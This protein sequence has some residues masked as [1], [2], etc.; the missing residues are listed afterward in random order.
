MNFEEMKPIYNMLI[1][2]LKPLGFSL[3]LQELE[4]ARPVV[5]MML[6]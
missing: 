1:Q 3:D 6:Q 2:Q 4:K 5:A